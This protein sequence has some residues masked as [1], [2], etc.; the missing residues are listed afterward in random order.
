[1]AAGGGLVHVPPSGLWRSHDKPR[2]VA[3]RTWLA[4]FRTPTVEAA[5]ATATATGIER[6]LGAY[7][8]ASIEDIGKW[9]GQPRLSRIKAALEILGDRIGQVTDEAGRALVDLDGAPA[10]AADQDAPPRFLSRWDS[11]LI[12][13][14]DR[15]RILPDAYASSVAKANADFLPTFLVDGFVVGCG[16]SPPPTA[17]RRS[18]SNHSTGSERQ[19]GRP[20][21]MRRNGSCAITSPTPRCTR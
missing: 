10:P 5:T 19:I 7:G 1:V 13:Y 9:L 18:R 8:P 2:Y 14:A 15:A 11:V 12:G 20:S 16:R 3:A 6:Y 17:G 4:P 21:R